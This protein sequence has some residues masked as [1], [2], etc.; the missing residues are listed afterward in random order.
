MSNC[1]EIANKDKGAAMTLIFQE[2]G[3]GQMGRDPNEEAVVAV[4]S[5]NRILFHRKMGQSRERKIEF[6]LVSWTIFLTQFF[7]ILFV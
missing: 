7:S 4:N 1:S 5:S 3:I 2:S 6:P